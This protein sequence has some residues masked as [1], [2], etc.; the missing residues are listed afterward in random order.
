MSDYKFGCSVVTGLEKITVEELQEKLDI[1]AE[2]D[3]R[4]GKLFFKLSSLE[5]V[6]ELTQLRSVE[7]V[8]AVV[9]VLNSGTDS[10]RNKKHEQN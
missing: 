6:H 1:V 8:F 5:R 9:D 10:L 7:H 3:T 4:R 2:S